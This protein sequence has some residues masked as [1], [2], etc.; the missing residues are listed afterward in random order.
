M[1]N[2]LFEEYARWSMSVK[3]ETSPRVWLTFGVCY[4]MHIGLRN[5]FVMCNY[6]LT[7]LWP[8]STFKC[9]A[10]RNLVSIGLPVLL[11]LSSESVSNIE[12]PRCT[13]T[14][15]QKN[16]PPLNSLYLCQILTDFQIFPLLE[17]VWNLLQNSYDITHFTLGMLLHYLGKLKI[18]IFC[19]YS[20]DMKENANK[21]HFNSL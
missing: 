2:R 19:R 5:V 16:F 11:V 8:Q 21:L 13:Y 1:L 10:T 15:S 7:S 20:A 14:V 6:A 3:K 4:K 12:L 9:F 17:S 18:Q